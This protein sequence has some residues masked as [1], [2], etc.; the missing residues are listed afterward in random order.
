[1]CYY[2]NIGQNTS[3]LTYKIMDI[4]NNLLMSIAVL[5]IVI[6]IV[7]VG[8]DFYIYIDKKKA[9]NK[10][11][12]F[13]EGEWLGINYYTKPDSHSVFFVEIDFFDRESI[14][15][16]IKNVCRLT[17]YCEMTLL[18]HIVDLKSKSLKSKH[19]NIVNFKNHIEKGDTPT[20]IKTSWHIVSTF[21]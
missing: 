14:S 20:E 19:S 17:S 11:K 3:L 8:L 18:N 16:T 15:G 2:Q 5:P 9:F 4:L 1:M 12:G 21:K 6:F 7:V 10:D 13:K